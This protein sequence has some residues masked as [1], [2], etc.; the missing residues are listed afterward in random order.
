MSFLTK[1]EIFSRAKHHLLTQNRR[2]ED[3]YGT[4]KYYGDGGAKD[5][6][7]V[8]IPENLYHPEIEKTGIS[9]LNCESA[10]EKMYLGQVLIECGVNILNEST[11]ELLCDL[12]EM[13]DVCEPWSWYDRLKSIARKHQLTF[14][15]KYT[16]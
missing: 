3:C 14:D 13:H 9:L 10:A 8:L 1:Q 16:A 4:V 15:E 7:G 12:Q 11:M 6:I 5:P 2:S